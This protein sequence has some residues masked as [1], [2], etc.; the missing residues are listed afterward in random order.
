MDQHVTR[1]SRGCAVILL[2]VAL[3]AVGP[4]ALAGP[5]PVASL[6]PA[7]DV[8]RPDTLI[9]AEPQP[10]LSPLDT[11]APLPEPLAVPSAQDQPHAPAVPGVSSVIFAQVHSPL[12]W[13]NTN[14]PGLRVQLS[15]EDAQGQ[16]KG[17]PSGAV[18]PVNTCQSLP[19]CV[20]VDPSTLYFEA[21]F[22]DPLDR[23]RFVAMRPGD[24]VHVVTSGD[25][26]GT[27]GPDQPEDKRV[28]IV[29][30]VA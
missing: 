3:A 26:P 30:I 14:V 16:L 1:G 9:V 2:V 18:K 23:G 24:Q 4:V 5:L 6:D 17:V 28:P 25:D 29:D 10:G 8:I 19:N 15:L 12:L 22:V 13:G 21:T 11:A 7:P 27:P 20:N